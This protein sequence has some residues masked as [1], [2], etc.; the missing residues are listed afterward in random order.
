M[1]CK[2]TSYLSLFT[3]HDKFSVLITFLAKDARNDQPAFEEKPA[4]VLSF[5]WLLSLSF[6]VFLEFVGSIAPFYFVVF[7][8]VQSTLPI[9]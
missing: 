6:L 9:R 2:Y 1:S 8:H 4:R 7:Q 5:V 3:R